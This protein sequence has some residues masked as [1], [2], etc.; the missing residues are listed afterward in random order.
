M[1]YV[2]LYPSNGLIKPTKLLDVLYVSIAHVVHSS[3]S[4]LVYHSYICIWEWYK[5][6]HLCSHIVWETACQ[7]YFNVNVGDIELS[8][9]SL[10]IVTLPI[11]NHIV[12]PF[13]HTS[14]VL[15][16]YDIKCVSHTIQVKHY[17]IMHKPIHALCAYKIVCF[18][19][20]LV[21]N[22]RESDKGQSLTVCLCIKCE[23]PKPFVL[24][25]VHV[26]TDSK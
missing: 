1:V 9:T 17:L 12:I 19:R 18:P 16:L 15:C 6:V 24:V 10:L 20:C 13:N 11:L 22:L 25:T 7:V 5:R 3:S 8:P 26:H 4:C 2:L 23:V 21:G 14:F